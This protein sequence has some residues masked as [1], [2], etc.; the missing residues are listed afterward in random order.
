MKAVVTG[1]DCKLVK[2]RRAAQYKTAALKLKANIAMWKMLPDL[3][4][5]KE[6]LEGTKSV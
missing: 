5:L 1:S 6:K 3:S 2:W 4:I